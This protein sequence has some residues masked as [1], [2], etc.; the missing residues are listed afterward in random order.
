MMKVKGKKIIGT[1]PDTSQEENRLHK[2]IY[3][4]SSK[5]SQGKLLQKVNLQ[6]NITLRNVPQTGPHERGVVQEQA[7]RGQRTEG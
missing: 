6:L 1:R 7:T 2:I 4:N 3:S 5:T